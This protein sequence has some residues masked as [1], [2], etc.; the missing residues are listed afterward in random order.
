MQRVITP[1]CPRCHGALW[2]VP[3]SMPDPC[4]DDHFRCERCGVDWNY[5]ALDDA[6]YRYDQAGQ[7]VERI[8][9]QP[10]LFGDRPRK[11]V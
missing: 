2:F 8:P 5:R 4:N 6:W 11:S 7:V 9:P 10:K 1:D 3:C